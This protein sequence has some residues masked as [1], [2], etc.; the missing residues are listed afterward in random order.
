MLKKINFKAADADGKR[1]CVCVCVFCQ[2]P[3]CVATQFW[4][5]RL[6]R[7]S[8]YMWL[9]LICAAAAAVEC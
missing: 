3:L 7:Y 2:L 1:V 8:V 4:L 5:T 9:V 6:Y